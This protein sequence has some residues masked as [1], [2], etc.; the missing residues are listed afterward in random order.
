MVRQRVPA[1]I[2]ATA[3]AVAFPHAHAAEP[4]GVDS[5]LK[6][7]MQ[8][9]HVPGLQVAVVRHG[10][11]VKLAAYGLANVQDSVP[12]DDR[13]LFQVNSITKAF[14]GVAV[15]QLVEAGKLEVSAP[16][17]R[18]L[19]GLPEAWHAVTVRQLLTHV[20][21][22][23]DIWDQQA[24]LIAD[25]EEA[26]WARVQTLPME[27]APGERFRYNQANYVL[28]GKLIDKLSGQP[29]SQFI[30]ERQF[31][32]AGMPASGFYDS[33]DVVSHSARVYR[34]AVGAG[35][36]KGDLVCVFDDFPPSLR[37][38]AGIN[39]T[40]EGIARWIIA[41]QGGKLLKEKSSLATLWTPGVLKDGSLSGGFGAP[42]PGY[43]LGWTTTLPPE[44]RAVGGIGGGRS[45]FFVYPDHDLAVVILTNFQGSSPH[46]LAFEVARQYVPSLSP[47][48]VFGQPPA[49]KALR[50]ELEKRGFEHAIEVA[51]E[52]EKKDPQF[53]PAELDLNAWG[54]LLLQQEQK[55]EAIEIF[56]LAVSLYPKSAN[57][58]ES[59]AEAY[60][61]NG[62]RELA[63]KNYRCSLE[64]NPKN[65]HAVEHLK[66]LEQ[67][68][69]GQKR[70]EQPE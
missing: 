61:L 68:G 22:I 31:D 47:S 13:T 16:V 5:Y 27:F 14:T 40:A 41:L 9:R 23:P 34:R 18:Y 67:E 30:K 12:V 49:M 35:H 32:I 55:R 3:C 36:H 38:A 46:L 6:G 69:A 29:F 21:G 25:G 1:A 26:S 51:R 70:S 48:E 42:F 37:T 28:L 43:A 44:E 2:L 7:Q 17:S 39:T 57:T 63:I 53:R 54:Y 10:K 11:I 66:G 15:M 60:E 58:Y 8:E 4:D 24:R 65:A 59:L 45:A 56:K 19:D 33:H 62:D 52:L 20:S 64:L 50:A